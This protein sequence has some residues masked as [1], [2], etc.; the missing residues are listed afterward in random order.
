MKTKCYLRIAKNPRGICKF[1]ASSKL[2]TKPL[3][4]GY[5]DLYPTICVG[6]TLDIDDNM[7]KEAQV[8]LTQKI[9]Q[10]TPCVNVEQED[11]T[12]EELNEEEESNEPE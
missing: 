6:L 8:E 9:E 3:G 11:I 1:E 4:N 12:L 5:K 10:S 2:N 7:F